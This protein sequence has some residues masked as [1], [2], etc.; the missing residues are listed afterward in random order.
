MDAASRIFQRFPLVARPRPTCPP[1][2]ERVREV[3]DLARKSE[4]D[5]SVSL[6]AVTYN[7]A[8][9]IASDCG[10]PDLARSLCWRHHEAYLRTQPLG[11]QV[12]RYALEPLVNLARLLVRSGDGEE[13]Y[14][15]LGALFQAVTVRSEIVIDGRSVSFS[16]LGGSEGDCRTL[17]QWMWAVLLAD[18][19]RALTSVGRWTDALDHL[20]QYRGV[21]ARMLDGRQVAIIAGITAGSTS[22]AMAQLADT[23]PGEPWEN[24]VTACLTVLA[25]RHADGPSDQ[26]LYTM[27]DG[28]QQLHRI[29]ELAVFHTRLGLTVIDAAD[30]VPHSVVRSIAADLVERTAQGGDGY[31]A[32][33]VLAHPGCVSLMSTRQADQLSTLVEA[34]ALG[35]GA[36]PAEVRS[37]LLAALELSDAVIART[38]KS[39]GTPNP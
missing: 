24:T 11:A 17:R 8:A 38:V 27:L 9:L 37:D 35:R 7:K 4:R 36:L 19:A 14:R 25:R 22:E 34:C 28:Y 6:A 20:R 2:A 1:L 33:D 29:P 12:A 15:V 16:R 30:G 39:G 23:V 31:A 3:G 21:G 32:R 13:A 5:S 26:D 10:L 18:G